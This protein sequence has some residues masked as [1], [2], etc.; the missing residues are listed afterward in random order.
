MS[1]KTEAMLLFV[2]FII[3]ILILI[4]L[5]VVD[6]TG[7]CESEAHKLKDERLRTEWAA[8]KEDGE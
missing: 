2:V 4:A 1:R 8:E 6:I 5:I 7:V 3:S